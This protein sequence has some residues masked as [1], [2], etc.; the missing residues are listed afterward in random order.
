MFRQQ[1][2]EGYDK[3]FQF[4]GN[5]LLLLLL[6]LLLL[7]LHCLFLC[8][9]FAQTHL[10]QTHI[11]VCVCSSSYHHLFGS[12]VLANIPLFAAGLLLTFIHVH[13]YTY[14]SDKLFMSLA[15]CSSLVP[16]HRLVLV[17]GIEPFSFIYSYRM[18]NCHMT[19]L[20][21]ESCVATVIQW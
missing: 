3:H 14:I 4:E 16:Y 21:V 12:F 6:L 13:M 10:K 20:F 17:H 5:T 1:I 11:H 2:N 7:F 9:G 8:Q 19:C 18:I 15:R